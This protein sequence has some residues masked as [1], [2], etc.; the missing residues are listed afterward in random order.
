VVGDLERI[1]GFLRWAWDSSSTRIE[2][3]AIGT[4]VFN[5]RFPSYWDGNLLRVERPGDATA[6][7]LITETDRMFGGFAHRSIF[8]FDADAGM[9]LA[10]SF[11]HEGW[12]VDRLVHMAR[13]REPDR[14]SSLAVEEATI[15][16]IRPLLVET[17]LHSHGGMTPAA[18]EANAAVREMLVDTTGVRFFV[19]K[20]DG[21]LAGVAEL[22]VHG[23]VAEIDNVNT[24]ERFRGRGVARAVVGSA[25]RE[26]LDGGADLVFL[27]ADDADWPKQLYGKLGFDP[28]GI[29]WQF[30]R[31]PLGESYR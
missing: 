19:A 5:D 3:S 9:R 8:L 26:G 16:E 31:T 1:E 13:R 2:A 28:V 14:E 6:A 12:E 20:V 23:G 29:C 4:A 27:I 24:L 30:T 18:A 10:P 21:A 7:T 15:E 25:A 17:N 11:R 22:I